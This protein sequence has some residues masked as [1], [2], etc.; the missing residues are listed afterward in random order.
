MRAKRVLIGVGILVLIAIC[1]TMLRGSVSSYNKPKWDFFPAARPTY[2]I[3]MAGTSDRFSWFGTRDSY[4]STCVAKLYALKHNYAFALIEDLENIDNRRYGRCKS[5]PQWNKIVAMKKYINDVDT[6]LWID[7][8]TVIVQFNTPLRNILPDSMR[9]SSCNKIDDLRELGSGLLGR[10][11]VADLP[12]GV[13]QAFFWASMDINPLYSLNLNTGV[14]ALRSGPQAEAFLDAVWK[15]G[16]DHRGFKKHDKNWHNKKK[17][18]GYYGWPWEQGAVWDVLL[19][20]AHLD[21]LR[22]TCV[23]PRMGP[24]ALNSIVDRWGD[25][26]VHPGRPFITHKPD[27]S[28]WELLQ[29]F[30]VNFDVDAALIQSQCHSSVASLLESNE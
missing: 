29:A 16:E 3:I 26:K 2:G 7:L 13:D 19:D 25:L 27:R 12:G 20:P 23:L 11:N 4:V 10:S 24:A 8:D 9:N 30:I 14:M 1:S 28:A 17:C 18:E 21:L 6:L 15:Q 5:F 22:A